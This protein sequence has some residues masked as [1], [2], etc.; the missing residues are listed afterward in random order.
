M[1]ALSP[2]FLVCLSLEIW[3][4]LTVRGF[5]SLCLPGL[6]FPIFSMELVPSLQIGGE[7]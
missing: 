3:D 2:G 1:G 6:N 5:T 4:Q 7:N